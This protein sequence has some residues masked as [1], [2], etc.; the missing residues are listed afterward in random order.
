MAWILEID[1]PAGV[2]SRKATVVVRN[3]DGNIL[4]TYF[5]QLS[6]Q[7]GR[8]RVARALA[9]KLNEDAAAIERKLEGAW[10]QALNR[11]EQ[12]PS[13]PEPDPGSRYSDTDG[14]LVWLKPTAAGP[15]RVALAN[16]T[17]RIVEEAV[18]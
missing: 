5:D 3:D 17:A 7:A 4:V 6:D 11:R 15:V 12:E 10:A 14:Y 2:R 9:A 13:E 16:F 18:R 1:V 8:R